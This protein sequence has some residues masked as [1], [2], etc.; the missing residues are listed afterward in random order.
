MVVVLL[1]LLLSRLS[2]VRLCATLRTV[3]RRAPLS[4]GFLRQ[5][6]WG[7]LPFPSPGDL[8]KPGIEPG[9][10]RRDRASLNQPVLAGGLLTTSAAWEVYTITPLR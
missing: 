4:M 5:A 6:Y 2:R 7:G 3:A 9:D 1:L 10:R 8:P